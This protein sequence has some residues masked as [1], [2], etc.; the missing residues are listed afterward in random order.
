MKHT[1]T[2]L[3]ALLFALPSPLRAADVSQ[4]SS[5]P[6]IVYILCDDLGYGDAEHPEEVARLTKLLEEIIANGRS[7]PGAKQENDAEIQIRK[8]QTKARKK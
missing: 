2:L 4:R 3:T 7:T 6:N 1:V 5:Q 8:G